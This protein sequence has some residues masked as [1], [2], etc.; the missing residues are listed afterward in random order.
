MDKASTQVSLT[1]PLKNGDNFIKEITLR[2][3]MAGELR[4][5]KLLDILQMD[6]NA[7]IPLLSRITTPMLTETQVNQLDPIDLIHN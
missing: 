5:I 3:P 1:N 4:G 7:Y 2:K 6:I